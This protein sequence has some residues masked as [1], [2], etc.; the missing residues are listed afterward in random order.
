VVEEVVV[1]KDVDERTETV[2]DTVRRK[3]VDIDRDADEPL[4][5]E[6]APTQRAGVD[7]RTGATPATSMDFSTYEADY[8]RHH[9]ATFLSH[10]TYADYEPAY[11]YGYELGT[12]ARYRGRNWADLEADA[13]R[14]WETRH[15]STWERFKDA[16]RYGWDKVTGGTTHSRDSDVSRI[17]TTRATTSPDFSTYDTGY[18]QHHST[19]FSNRGA[20]EDYVPAYRYGYDLAVDERYRGRMWEGLEEDFRRGWE[21]QRPGTWE[22]FKDAIR[23]GW[24]TVR[25]RV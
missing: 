10:G 25:G 15:P 5:T 9:S 13:Y 20:Y 7:I 14:D 3:D 12:S 19:T 22:R 6:P 2:R 24:D 21:I 4:R 16:I 8:R 23:H 17:E 11:R 1:R 18:R